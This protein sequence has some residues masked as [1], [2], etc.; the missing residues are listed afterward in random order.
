MIETFTRD[1]AAVMSQTPAWFQKHQGGRK[2]KKKKNWKKKSC[3]E[4]F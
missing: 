2:R 3:T 4:D 1:E